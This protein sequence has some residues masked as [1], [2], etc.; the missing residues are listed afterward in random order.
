MLIY[1]SAG[2]F[3]GEIVTLSFFT[4]NT[5]G[6]L[7]TFERLLFC[8]FIFCGCIISIHSLKFKDIPDTVAEN[9]PWAYLLVSFLFLFLYLLL[10]K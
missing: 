5:H 2:L 9:L 8:Q 10:L 3:L 6:F 7:Y 1:Y 4:G